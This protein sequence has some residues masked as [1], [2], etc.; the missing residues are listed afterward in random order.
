MKNVCSRFVDQREQVEV[1][2]LED[3]CPIDGGGLNNVRTENIE[4]LR[5]NMVTLCL[6]LVKLKQI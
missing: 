2:W 3:Q 1:L 4:Q 5:K 6:K